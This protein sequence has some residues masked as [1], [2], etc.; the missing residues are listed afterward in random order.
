[1]HARIVAGVP[2][3]RHPV[4][5]W[6]AA[7]LRKRSCIVLDR[8]GAKGVIPMHPAGWSEAPLNAWLGDL[9]NLAE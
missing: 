4:R 2:L 6:A 1:V 8:T 3:T 7:P 9:E 5:A